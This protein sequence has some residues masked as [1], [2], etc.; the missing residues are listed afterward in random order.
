MS[1]LSYRWLAI[2]GLFACLS[3]PAQAQLRISYSPD[4]LT[5]QQIQDEFRSIV[6]RPN[7]EQKIHF[8]YYNPGPGKAEN[9]KISLEQVDDK[10]QTKRVLATGLVGMLKRDE[11]APV[12]LKMVGE[13]KDGTPWP[14]L[15]GPPFRLRLVV[16]NIAAPEPPV[17]IPIKLRQPSEY[18][19]VAAEYDPSGGRLS[20]RVA[21]KPGE[22]LASPVPVELVLDKAL[23]RNLI[24]NKS[25]TRLQ[26]L[27]R[28]PV[29][30]LATNVSFVGGLVPDDGRVMI[31]ADGYERAFLFNCNFQR[32]GALAR[33]EDLPRLRLLAPRYSLPSAKTPVVLEV[34]VPTQALG[35]ADPLQLSAVELLFDRTGDGT[36]RPEPGSP[37]RGL[38]DQVIE[39]KTEGNALVFKTI[40]KD[41]VVNLNTEGIEGRRAIKGRL[42]NAAGQ[43]KIANEDTL[44]LFDSKFD[45][46]YAPLTFAA[47]SIVAEFVL[48]S[49]PPEGMKIVGVPAKAAPEQAISPRLL[50]KK[51]TE[52][53]APIK[54]RDV[55]FFFGEVDKDMKIPE[56]LVRVEATLEKEEGD[57]M[58]FAP[59]A[60]LIAPPETGKAIFVSALAETAT[61]VRRAEKTSLLVTTKPLVDEPKVAVLTTVAGLV[62]RGDLRQPG[63]SVVLAKAKP[64]KTDVAKTATTTPEGAFQFKDVPP[65]VYVLSARKLDTLD[66]KVIT[67]E[68]NQPKLGVNLDLKIR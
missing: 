9:V 5:K 64:E 39:F 61:G 65:G 40:V 60:D 14:R 50:V 3:S 46:Q 23:V 58:V 33:L 47:D 42:V 48:D 45:S 41:R 67:V 37:F 55:V 17:I 15:D 18:L 53:Q 24:E 28:D 16:D 31:T 10:G 32:R 49:T 36:Y 62:L 43:I 11:A 35:A 19:D 68:K 20:V 44:S 2:I 51:R 54:I 30:L 12:E 66:R 6:L 8:W 25:G 26:Q 29:E 34:D 63:V 1:R 21:P 52:K 22:V 56:P 57:V 38:R 7:T 4:P 13:I 27:V 59:K